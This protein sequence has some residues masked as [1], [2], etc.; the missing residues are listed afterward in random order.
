[1]PWAGASRRGEADLA[2]VIVSAVSLLV[3]FGGQR[4]A[5][6]VPWGLVR[7]PR[8]HRR[9]VGAGPA[10]AGRRG[11]RPGAAGAS[12]ARA[13]VGGRRRPAG[14]ARRR[15]GPGAGGSRGGAQRRPAVRRPAA[16]TGSTPTRSCSPPA[17]PTSAPG[18][19]GGIGVAGSLSKT[20]ALSDARGRTQMAGLTAAALAA[21]RHRRD[22][23]GALGA[24]QGRPQRHRGQR[25]LEAHGLRGAPPLRPGA[26]ERH[27]RRRSRRRG[28]AGLRAAVRPAAR[29]RR[30]G[31]RA[32]STAPAGSTSK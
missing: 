22:R 12:D 10:G 24:A 20:A 2:T 4:L 16:A 31:A 1:M 7:A 6:R 18:L 25:G 8:W 28:G 15:R 19:F 9:L 5:P 29:G 17:R 32:W 21:R 11:R 26:A 3:L 27:R 14:T 23:A 30:F 13:A